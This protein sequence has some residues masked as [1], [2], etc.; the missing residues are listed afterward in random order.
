MSLA[1]TSPE[2]AF[3]LEQG[4]A[5]D[6]VEALELLDL[7][8]MRGVDDFRDDAVELLRT[9]RRLEA[10]ARANPLDFIAWL[11][12][13]L[14]FFKSPGDKPTLFRTGVRGGKTTAG[15]ADVDWRAR[16]VHPYAT[17][18]PKP[19]VRIAFI[20]TDRQQQGVAI[21]KLFYELVPKHELHPET[22]FN[23]KVGFRGHVQMCRYKNG[24]EVIFYSNTAGPKV[25]QGSEFHHIHGDEPISPEMFSEA[26]NRVRN[27]GGT[28]KLT[29][30]PLN[31]AVPYLEAM[32]KENRIHDLHYRLTE[33]NQT[34]PIT[35]RVR[36]RKDGVPWDAAYIAFLREKYKNDPAVGVML[37]GD[38]ERRSEG[39]YFKCFNRSK[40]V[41][42]GLPRGEAKLHIGID[43]AAANRELGMCAV[44]SAV[45]MVRIADDLEVPE[46][47]ILD[48][49]VIPGH[50]TMEQL[51]RAILTMLDR[52]GI[53]WRELD[54]VFGDIPAKARGTNNSNSNLSKWLS[55]FLG[56]SRY[57]LR[58]TV[59]N[60]KE[61]DGAS[62]RTRRTKD[63][64]CRWFYSTMAS[65]RLHIH[66]DAEHFAKGCE[67]WDYH[68][69][70]PLKD[71][72]DAGM[73]GL[74]D[75]WVGYRAD[76]E[77]RRLV[78]D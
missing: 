64:R 38:F 60:A 2:T 4:L 55:R 47:W 67:Q 8:A 27:T 78:F 36:R 28:V 39:Q 35:G 25:L 63:Q 23:P 40:H 7:L 12:G 10:C 68:D 15:V 72:L 5:R 32:A 18:F 37:D 1:A 44:L 75:Y 26:E 13:Q 57:A 58:P 42:K 22:E 65:D 69:R 31:T 59:G 71:V 30:T 11:P 76:G 29:L 49:V 20:T 77:L 21:Q 73:Y 56:V 41:H 19:P 50:S 70:H 53:K 16:G 33:E 34:S 45:Q 48:E 14:A 66:D 3:L 46:V 24:S 43:Y 74:R 6:L 54:S 17:W 62:T 52:R 9:I 61:G 51:A